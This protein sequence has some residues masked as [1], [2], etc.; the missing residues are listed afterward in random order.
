MPAEHVR[1]KDG[2][3]QLLLRRPWLKLI[4]CSV[5]LRV[6]EGETW[7]EASR[8][9]RELR[10]FERDT[11]VRLGGGLCPHCELGLRRRRRRDSQQ[12]AA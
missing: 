11:V 7:V 12:V 5:C 2:V 8:A 6:Q 4:T 1:H 9:I 3:I 10:T